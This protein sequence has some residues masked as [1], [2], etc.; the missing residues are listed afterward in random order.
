MNDYIPGDTFTLEDIIKEFG[1]GSAPEPKPE[2]KPT[3]PAP[4]PKPEAPAP[5]PEIESEPDM[6]WLDEP[7]EYDPPWPPRPI[8]EP[9]KNRRRKSRAEGERKRKPKKLRPD[10]YEDEYFD[11][12]AVE[13]DY[14]LSGRRGS[15]KTPA[16]AERLPELPRHVRSAEH[17]VRDTEHAAY[18]RG[19]RMRICLIVT[20]VNVLLAVYNGLDLHWIRGF[21][22]VAAMG[23]ICLLLLITAMVSAYDVLAA[24]FKQLVRA[25]YGAETLAALLSVLALPETV[26]AIRALRLPLCAPV[27]LVLLCTL[28]AR[29]R[30]DL[31]LRQSAQTV[32]H[33]GA[34]AV[35][36]RR[37][38]N[39]WDGAPAA[40][41]AAA[42]PGAFEAMLEAEDPQRSA[43]RWYVP[44]AVLLTA[45]LSAVGA[46][47]GRVNY[48]RLWTAMLLLAAPL[49]GIL[50]FA[51]P[52]SLI[53]ARLSHARAALNGW[54][55]ARVLRRCGVMF[56]EDEALFPGDSLR[57][58]GVKVFG[59]YSSSQVMLFAASVLNA[60]D[61]HIAPRLSTGEP[62]LPVQALRVYDKGGVEGE[63]GAQS[64]LV[65]TWSF[66]QKMGVHMDE[67]TR[68]RQALYVSVRGELAGL[69]A[70]RY[71]ASPRVAEALQRLSGAASPA[72]VLT[73]SDVLLTP[74]LLRA[75][76]RLPLKR[77]VCPPLRARRELAALPADM[78]VPGA[79]L[80][81]PSLDSFTA[82]VLGARSLVGVT[83]AELIL[84]LLAAFTG[85]AIVF[86]LSI[87]GKMEQLGCARLLAFTA[88]WALISGLALLPVLK[89]NRIK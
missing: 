38:D 27:C 62:L 80:A 39:A 25:D 12:E 63:I 22:N 89:K 74:A 11:L 53:S 72:P 24:G 1:S 71:E 6:S 56:V 9:V 52:F 76:F 68:I 44:A 67:G 26:F 19:L 31:A 43:L 20:V 2:E 60:L 35:S 14:S 8:E 46:I 88:L 28:W 13:E 78:A 82:A 81:R 33:A 48:L 86:V 41:C 4:E 87:T 30:R 77:L 66:M 29:D 59:G 85:I 23:V 75:K 32:L 10:L 18:G 50:S 36:V 58:S 47:I 15:E 34:E 84:G 16:R 79:V 7:P 61:C 73:G 3:A 49:G 57:L 51:L 42:Q 45:L 64:V 65:G 69:I 70:L 37:I 83:H 5:E 17:I 21:E 55:G 54:Y 40:A